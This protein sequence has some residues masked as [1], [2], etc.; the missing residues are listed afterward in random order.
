VDSLL[1]LYAA[2]SPERAP[3]SA[4]AAALYALRRSAGAAAHLA[5]ALHDR[6]HPPPV[7]RSCSGCQVSQAAGSALLLLSA[8]EAAPHDL[9][10]RL[11]E[12]ESL[13]AA[14]RRDYLPTSAPALARAAAVLALNERRHEA[15]L[16]AR[17]LHDTRPGHSPSLCEDCLEIMARRRAEQRR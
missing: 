9:G 8:G 12:A 6:L 11:Q 3:L 17:T 15:A 4:V 5:C 16:V 13:F 7:S 10:N 1:A 14:C 2:L